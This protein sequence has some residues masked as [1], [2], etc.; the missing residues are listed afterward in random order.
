MTKRIIVTIVGL[1]LLIGA[2]AG[3]KFLQIRK[4]IDQ[5]A[6][7]SPPPETVTSTE[8]VSAAWETLLPAVGSLKAVQGMNVAAELAG[9]V[10]GIHFQSGT[11]VAKGTLLLEQDSSSEQAL[12][13]GANSA[14][15]LAKVNLKRAD[16]L[17]AEK[18]VSQAEYDSAVT[19][20]RQ[21]IA[22]AD[23]IHATI[24]KKTIRAPFSGRLGIR[25]VDLGQQLQSGQKIVSL[26]T[27]DPI[28]LN[29]FLP[30]QN[31]SK[32]RTGLNVRVTSDA[33]PNRS[34][35]GQLRMAL[36]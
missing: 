23:D 4:M 9:K 19:K 17:L 21:A 33:F 30:Q 15:E 35:E 1:L 2:L 24:A 7:F 8:V 31:L 34:I 22:E 25:Q 6:Q 16:K 14:S 10:T 32:L 12:L 18:I 36:V 5:G 13:P 27:L 20:L 3:T 28:Y 26:Q 11:M 29:F